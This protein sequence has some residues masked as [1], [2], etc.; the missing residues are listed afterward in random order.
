MQAG[1]LLLRKWLPRALA[2]REPQFRNSRMAQARI[3]LRACDLLQTDG[4]LCGERPSCIDAPRHQV[5]RRFHSAAA[6]DLGALLLLLGAAQPLLPSRK[7]GR[8][9]QVL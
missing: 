6:A 3:R 2:A 4:A 9:L 8:N 5:T 1:E 7:P